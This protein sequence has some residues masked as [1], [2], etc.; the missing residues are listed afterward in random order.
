MKGG[1]PQGY[2]IVEV[3]IFLAVSSA[4]FVAV[5][6]TFAGRQARTEFS[7]AAREMESRL[8]D[9]INDVSTGY[10]ARPSN[11]NCTA[12]A[13]G[14]FITGGSNQQGANDDCI[15]IGRVA[16]FDTGGPQYDVYTV[17]GL[18]QATSGGINRDVQNF[19][20]AKPLPVTNPGNMIENVGVPSGLQLANMYYERTGFPRTRI[21]AIGFFS[22][23]GTYG[24][25]GLE[26]GKLAVNVLPIISG[27]G[28]Q[29][30]VTAAIDGI[31]NGS[32]AIQNPNGGVS[33][34][35]NATG[36]NQHAVLKIGGSNRQLTTNLA[37]NNGACPAV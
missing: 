36:T 8:Q 19:D 11:F 5:A 20:E 3:M 21:Y 28:S 33:I 34:C 1:A 16:H 10:Y 14:P 9:I 6:V 30:S 29:G 22:E 2:T 26:P 24:A 4:L 37:I 15:F 13:S 25:Q 27:N 18:R 17:A 23:F 7:V 35:M 31:N 32:T 12:S